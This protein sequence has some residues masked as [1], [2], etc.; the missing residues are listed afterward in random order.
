M[1]V[2]YVGGETTAQIPSYLSFYISVLDELID[3]FET[4][5]IEADDVDPFAFAALSCYEYDETDSLDTYILNS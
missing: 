4:I 5:E 3:T 1:E 2:G